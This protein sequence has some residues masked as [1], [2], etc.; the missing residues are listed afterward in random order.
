MSQ[1]PQILW[2]TLLSPD[3]VSI[4]DQIN[5]LG[6]KFTILAAAIAQASGQ[7]LNDAAL[8]HSTVF[9][10]QLQHRCSVDSQIWNDFRLVLKHPFWFT[11][12]AK[13]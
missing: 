13:S 1:V 12:M 11:G 2:N 10:M 7:D 5:L 8:S 6:R 4:L 3:V 9:C